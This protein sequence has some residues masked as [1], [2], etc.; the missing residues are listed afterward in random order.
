MNAIRAKDKSEKRE[1]KKKTQYDEYNWEELYI[2]GSLDKLLVEDLNKYLDCH[3]IDK[4][5]KLKRESLR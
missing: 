3:D 5:H 4:G 2:T 1:E